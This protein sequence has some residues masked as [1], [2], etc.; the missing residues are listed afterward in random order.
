MA[1]KATVEK[2]Q[3]TR[4]QHMLIAQNAEILTFCT[5]ARVVQTLQHF[6]KLNDSQTQ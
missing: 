4:Q 3:P 6:Q 5:S 2:P 1:R